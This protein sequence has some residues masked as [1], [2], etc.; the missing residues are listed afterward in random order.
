MG[1]SV[2]DTTLLPGGGGGGGEGRIATA[3]IVRKILSKYAILSRDLSK[4]VERHSRY[5]L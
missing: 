2:E 4:I 1:L 3:M 5:Q